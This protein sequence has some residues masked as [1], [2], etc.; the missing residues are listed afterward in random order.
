MFNRKVFIIN[1]LNNSQLLN[2][3]SELI[4]THVIIRK[5]GLKRNNR[6]YDSMDEV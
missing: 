2:K 4:N 6:R 1:T 3:N 5:K